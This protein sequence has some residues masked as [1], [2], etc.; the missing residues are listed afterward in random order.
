MLINQANNSA[1]WSSALAHL[2]LGISNSPIPIAKSPSP[3]SQIPISFCAG[4]PLSP[5]GCSEKAHFSSYVASGALPIGKS[6]QLKR[7]RP[8]CHYPVC[9]GFNKNRRPNRAKTKKHGKV[10]E[11]QRAELSLSV[12]QQLEYAS[13]IQRRPAKAANARLVNLAGVQLPSGTTPSDEAALLNSPRQLDP[14]ENVIKTAMKFEGQEC[15][16]RNYPFPGNKSTVFCIADP[17]FYNDLRLSLIL[18]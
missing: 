5:M 9:N 17:T 10:D 3:I 1:S 7:K 12:R 16:S 11:S 6:A 14:R 4:K 15:C 8:G 2:H 18:T 13:Q